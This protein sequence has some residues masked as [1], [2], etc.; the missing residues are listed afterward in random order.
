ME[1]HISQVNSIGIAELFSD[2]V[3]IH[4]AQDA[5]DIMMNCAYQE[6]LNLI[7]YKKNLIPAFFDLKTGIAGDVLQKFSTYNTRLAIIG[8]FE[9]VPSGSLRDFIFES[10]RA[11]R[12]NFLKSAGTARQVLSSG[13]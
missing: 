8:D 13:R 11:G 7:V 6:A 4:N 2:K 1:L 3:E 5:L 12:I 10:N 9:D